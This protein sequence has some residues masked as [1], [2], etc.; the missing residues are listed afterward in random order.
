MQRPGWVVILWVGACTWLS[1]CSSSS[2]SAAPGVDG[3]VDDAATDGGAGDGADAATGMTAEEFTRRYDAALCKQSVRC[4]AVAPSNE[5]ACNASYARLDSD[6]PTSLT[7]LA[8]A[9]RVAID[10]AA[11]EKCFQSFDDAACPG[12][13]DANACAAAILP[14]TPVGSACDANFE[15]LGGSCSKQPGCGGT[16]I[17]YAVTGGDCSAL[18]CAPGDVCDHGTCAHRLDAGKPCAGDA[19]LAGL[20]C[21]ADAS[22]ATICQT[23]AAPAAEGMP[24]GTGGCAKGLACDGA[25]KIC[26]K[27]PTSGACS[28]IGSCADGYACV[29]AA[30]S[31]TCKPWSGIVE[32]CDPTQR[33]E[34][35]GC[36]L[37]L[38]CDGATSK[39]KPIAQAV[40]SPCI[41]GI[42]NDP[43][44]DPPLYCDSVSSTCKARAH[45]GA[46]CSVGADADRS[47][48][49]TW[50]TCSSS[51]TCAF[52]C[53]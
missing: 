40:G 41:S 3:A 2:S 23:I 35:S 17:A 44:A 37:D 50:G 32:A 7:K 11:A 28:G 48:A 29:G 4:G 52:A 38:V 18:L 6:N 19:C 34:A 47:F 39:C 14:Q 1:A 5:A 24:C 21:A 25:S 51:N 36:T 31:R 53:L 12:G 20:V 49:C 16:C 10:G 43:Y 9:H 8:A 45:Y 27:R 22:G 26:K 30:G 46:A 13:N 15:C 42:C 33:F